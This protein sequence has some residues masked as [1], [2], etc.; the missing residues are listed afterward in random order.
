MDLLQRKVEHYRYC[1]YS[2]EPIEEYVEWPA[3][4]DLCP[5]PAWGWTASMKKIFCSL[6][7]LTVANTPLAVA[8]WAPIGE[9]KATVIATLGG[10]VQ[11]AVK[12]GHIP[13]ERKGDF[14]S[15]LIT[16]GNERGDYTLKEF[17]EIVLE[18]SY[19]PLVNALLDASGGC[20]SF[21]QDN[22]DL[23]LDFFRWR[24]RNN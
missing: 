11:C 16:I 4:S 21:S 15:Y 13:P 23:V 22:K 8:Q 18:A 5:E 2:G 9:N 3:P 1:V 17:K 12:H 10:I 19:P 6:L 7:M 20:R 14:S 24:D